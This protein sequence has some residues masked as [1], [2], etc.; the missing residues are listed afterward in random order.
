[1]ETI[2][3][4]TKSTMEVV[5]QT[6]RDTPSIP[7]LPEMKLRLALEFEELKE[8]AQ[9]MG[10][11]GTFAAITDNFSSSIWERMRKEQYEKF[12]EIMKADEKGYQ[13]QVLKLADTN[14]VNLVEVFDACLDQRVVASG[15]DLCFG[16]QH[17][18]SD[19]DEAVYV[20]NM[21]KFD[22]EADVALAGVAAYTEKGI[23]TYIDTQGE[24]HV[25]KRVEDGKY[26]KSLN[27]SPVN[28]HNLV[29]LNE[30]NTY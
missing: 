7:T 13:N 14:I 6:V 17:I 18:I 20:S 15:T 2:H 5:G 12:Q 30:T 16:F 8:K 19:G 22:T 1:M 25:I 3:E 10:L 29:G 26:L 9:A 4:L 23:S 24:Y 27:Y 11:E 21:S 28:L